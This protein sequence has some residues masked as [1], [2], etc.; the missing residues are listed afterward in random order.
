MTPPLSHSTS[1]DLMSVV[2]AGGSLESALG[3]LTG[4]DETIYR[5]TQ[6]ENALSK[7]DEYMQKRTA[8]LRMAING[9]TYDNTSGAWTKGDGLEAEYRRL[10]AEINKNNPTI[11]SARAQTMAGVML[12]NYVATQEALVEERFPSTFVRQAAKKKLKKN[13]RDIT[14]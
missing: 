2:M 6:L 3:A 14:L 5:N 13:V 1:H 10:L 8:A 9:D 11:P 7:P 12:R 4:Y